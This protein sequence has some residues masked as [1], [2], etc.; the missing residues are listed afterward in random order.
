MRIFGGICRNRNFVVPKGVE[1]RPTAGIVREALF[2]ICQ[3]VIEG[4]S[5]LDVFAGSG[6]MG[7]EALSRGAEEVVFIDK[8]KVAVRYIKKNLVDLHLEAN[9]RVVCGDGIKML[10]KIEGTFDIIYIDPPYGQGGYSEGERNTYAMLAL[11]AIDEGVLLKDGGQLFLEESQDSK[12]VDE[13]KATT[14]TLYKKRSFGR[15]VLR[16]YRKI[17]L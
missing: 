7:L 1:V 6:A 16:Q 5:F 17:S 11:R 10:S 15:T 9:G 2:N 14:L 8:S 13:F 12:E 3:N 4:S